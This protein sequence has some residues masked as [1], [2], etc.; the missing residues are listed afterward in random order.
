MGAWQ[1]LFS[2]Q[3]Q[4]HARSDS[5]VNCTKILEMCISS[6]NKKIIY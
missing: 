5:P 6:N 1:N 2:Q 3:T 4:I